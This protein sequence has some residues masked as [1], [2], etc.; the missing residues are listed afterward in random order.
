MFL[1]T[2][3]DWGDKMN[4][5]IAKF[6]GENGSMGLHTDDLY[7]VEITIKDSML[8]VKWGNGKRCPYSSFEKFFENWELTKYV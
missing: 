5:F 4:T 7:R 3:Q 8:W 6:I 1:K 2:W